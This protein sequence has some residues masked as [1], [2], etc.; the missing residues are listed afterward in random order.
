MIFINASPGNIFGIF[1]KYTPLV[2]PFGIGYL[3]SVL[4]QAGRKAY[5]IDQITEHNTMSKILEITK[6]LKQPYIFGFSVITANYA[7]SLLLAHKLKSEYPDCKIIF[8]GVH[9][10]NVPEEVLENSFVDVVFRGEAEDRIVELYDTIKSNHDSVNIPNVSYRDDNDNIIHNPDSKK[11]VDISVLPEFP[12][13]LFDK[14]NYD[15]ANMLS[16]RGCPHHCIFCSKLSKIS[17][18]RFTSTATI[19]K[20][21]SVLYHAYHKNHI[22]FADDNFLQD[23]DRI[24]NLIHAIKKSEFYGKVTFS[25]ATRGDSC[26]ASL[27]KELYESGFA[28]INFGVETASESVMKKL[29]KGETLAQIADAVLMAKNIGF[30]VSINFIFGLPGETHHDR[31]QAIKLAKKLKADLVKYSNATPFPGTQFYKTAKREKIINITGNYENFNTAATMVENPFHKRKLPYIPKGNTE[32]ALRFDILYGYLCFYLN[33]KR[34]KNIFTKPEY[35]NAWYNFGESRKNIIKN[36]PGIIWLLI[37]L[38]VKFGLVILRYPFY[39]FR[40]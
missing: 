14:E 25:F 38:S 17:K 1:Q 12:Y 27:L 40:K 26:E 4:K 13:H 34:L 32:N 29:K 11:P 8:G 37:M 30:H 19:I 35:S 22:L 2:V 5:F 18:F 3:M 39:R 33:L 20:D 28:N 7:N 6:S 31:M 24:W 16:S 21:I 9:P 15:I 36:A 23:H 10:S